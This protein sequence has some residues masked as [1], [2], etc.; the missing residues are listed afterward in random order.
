MDSQRER[1]AVPPYV[2]YRTFKSFLQELAK[3]V[4]HRIDKS[5]LP[6]LSG[7]V[8]SQLLQA[9]KFFQ[10]INADGVP[11]QSLHA[12]VRAQET[13]DEYKTV[14]KNLLLRFYP[15]LFV[16]PNQGLEKMTAG[17][18]QEHFASLANGDTVQKCIAFFIPAAKDA[19]IQLGPYI[20]ARKK[21]PTGRPAKK[22]RNGNMDANVSSPEN[23]N[24]D[25]IPSAPVTTWQQ[26]LL[27]KFPTFDPEWPDNVKTKW[28]D[29]F[30]ALM[31]KGGTP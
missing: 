6:T 19:G 11:E 21:R 13:D 20:V 26:M 22:G 23:G 31:K 9:L 3:G 16:S 5:I 25:G 29:A 15:F 14:L 27:T 10:L 1:G 30:D 17:Q 7:G 2:S 4:P 24:V 8:Q 18:L 12:L 28:F